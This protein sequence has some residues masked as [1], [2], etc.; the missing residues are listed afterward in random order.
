M[1][2]LNKAVVVIMALA[3]LLTA[4]AGGGSST[5]APSSNA[6]ASN[7]APSGDTA[8]AGEV[9]KP[10]EMYLF[11]DVTP[12]IEDGQK[13]IWQLLS[14][15]QGINYR[16]E[17]PP[18]AEYPQKLSVQFL[19]N[20]IP[21]IVEVSSNDY[22]SYARQGVFHPMKSLIDNSDVLAGVPQDMLDAVTLQGEIYGMQKEIGN[23]SLTYLRGDWME[24]MG[25]EMPKTFEEYLDLLR[26]FR[27]EKGATPLIYAGNQNNINGLA[28]YLPD[29]FQ[30]YNAD[31]NQTESGE[32][33]D[34]FAQ[35][36]MV[37]VISRLASAYQEGLIDIDVFTLSTSDARSRYYTGTVGA[38][39]YW[40]GKW[41]Q[42]INREIQ[43]NIPEAYAV[44]MPAFE[45]VTFVN[46][47]APLYAM[48]VLGRNTPEQNF[49]YFYEV[50]FDGAEGQLWA[51]WG[52][53]GTTWENVNGELKPLPKPSDPNTPLET[54]QKPLIEATL[55]FIPMAVDPFR[56]TDPVYES[57]EIF[58]ASAKTPTLIPPVESY[59]RNV[60]AIE[61]LRMELISRAMKGE[62]TPDAAVEQYKASMA[63]FESDKILAELAEF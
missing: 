43:K 57:T 40:S 23:G 53:E 60:A 9:E 47:V 61:M 13:E 54:P 42:N 46:R 32:W 15:M 28:L 12:E 4:C 14:D 22:M 20:D 41:N 52:G 21:D 56:F 49:K 26:R 24:E 16:V 6:S 30:G 19:S 8:T 10:K 63:A 48:P 58:F 27:D 35:P 17:K 34:G 39:P 2:T 37:D 44:A 45:G 59:I 29:W 33:V 11:I 18:H 31:F 25:A 7:A 55:A 1:K 62:I 38:F 5:V 51:T 3:L 36:G 50:I